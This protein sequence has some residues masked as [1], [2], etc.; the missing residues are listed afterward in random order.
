[1]LR[2]QWIQTETNSHTILDLQ[3][4]IHFIQKV[5]NENPYTEAALTQT[6]TGKAEQNSCDA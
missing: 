1:V 5:K 2:S 4:Y 6:L 3:V